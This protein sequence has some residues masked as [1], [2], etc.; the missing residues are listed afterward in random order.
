MHQSG[1]TIAVGIKHDKVSNKHH[2]RNWNS[3]HSSRH[4][5]HE[6]VHRDGH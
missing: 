6:N 2:E 4:V 5:E 1:E 3:G